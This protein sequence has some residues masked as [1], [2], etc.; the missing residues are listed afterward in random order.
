MPGSDDKKK[1]LIRPSSLFKQPLDIVAFTKAEKAA[2]PKQWELDARLLQ[3]AIE[4]GMTEGEGSLF[5]DVK[6]TR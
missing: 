1:A 4:E 5:T 2:I 3:V 6:G